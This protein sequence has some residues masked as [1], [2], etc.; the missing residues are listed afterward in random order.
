MLT[1][2]EVEAD[3]TGTAVGEPYDASC[4]VWS[5]G[6]T[7]HVLLCAELPFDLPEECSEEALVAAARNVD[8][9]FRRKEWEGEAM[10]PARDFVRSC[11]AVQRKDRPSAARLLEHPWV[12]GKPSS[13]GG[14]N[15][16]VNGAYVE[17]LDESLAAEAKA[18]SAS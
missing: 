4:D 8:L 2:L 13:G 1:W 10:A 9:S 16:G 6:V 12:G 7:T 14:V 18:A 17:M 5:V 3:E 11:M 15:G